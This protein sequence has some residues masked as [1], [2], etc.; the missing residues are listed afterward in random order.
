VSF[1]SNDKWIFI[2]EQSNNVQKAAFII[3]KCKETISGL[4]SYL[5][6]LLVLPSSD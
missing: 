3:I 2:L 5:C 1:I 4:L 6:L